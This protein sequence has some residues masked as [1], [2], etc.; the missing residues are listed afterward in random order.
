MRVPRLL[1]A[2]T[3]R[4]RRLFRSRASDCAATIRGRRL[5]EE[6][7]YKSKPHS[8]MPT[9]L[10]NVSKDER[11]DISWKGG[12]VAVKSQGVFLVNASFMS[13]S[14]TIRSIGRLLLLL[15]EGVCRDAHSLIHINY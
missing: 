13:Y 11:C 14:C 9:E 7:W 15:V 8:K 2:A 10:R 4:G 1:A 6:I 3:I 12:E 5:F